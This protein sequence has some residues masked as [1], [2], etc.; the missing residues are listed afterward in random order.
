M[1]AW[2]AR[3]GGDC[4]F[5]VVSLTGLAPLLAAEIR[6]A[7]WAHTIDTTPAAWHPMWLRTLVKSCRTRG[8]GSLLELDPH[9]AGWTTHSGPVNRIVQTMRRDVEPVHHSRERTREL[10]YLDTDYWGFRFPQRRSVFD[11]TAI[12]Q[13]WLR[14]LTWEYLA[15]VLDGPARPRTQGPFDAIRRAMVSFGDYLTERA[16]DRG[17]SPAQLTAATA[18]G[19]VADF[20]KRIGNGQPTRGMVNSDGSSSPASQTTYQLTMNAMRRVM[21]AA[22]DSGAAEAIGLPR[23]FIVAIPYGGNTVKRNPRPFSDAVLRV[24]SDPANI[25]LLGERDPHDGGPEFVKSSET[26]SVSSFGVRVLAG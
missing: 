6:Y 10:G 11:L 5:G 7:L 2:L 8:V 16:P 25:A 22:L 17:N 4:G 23:E 9:D 1:Q 21:R 18:R 14:D 26:V 15:D 24:V 13:P 3:A 12:A 20:T 19:F